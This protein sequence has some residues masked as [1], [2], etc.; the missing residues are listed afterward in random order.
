MELFCLLK[1][2]IGGHAMAPVEFDNKEF[3]ELANDKLLPCVW[4]LSFSCLRLSAT[5]RR[6][7]RKSP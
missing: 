4:K 5:E 6:I 2:H 1:S 7:V 3:V